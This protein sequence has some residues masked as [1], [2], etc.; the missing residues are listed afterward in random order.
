VVAVVAVVAVIGGRD[1]V[2]RAPVLSLNKSNDD[3]NRN[4]S[5]NKIKM[6]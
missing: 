1:V 4:N 2:R 3:S 6:T 5:I